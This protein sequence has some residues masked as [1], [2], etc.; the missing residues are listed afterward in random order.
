MSD[1][2]PSLHPFP[3]GTKTARVRLPY[4][5]EH[6]RSASACQCDTENF[7]YMST[8]HDNVT[9]IIWRGKQKHVNIPRTKQTNLALFKLTNESFCFLLHTAVKTVAKQK[10]K[11]RK[12]CTYYHLH[13]RQKHNCGVRSDGRRH[14]M[15]LEKKQTVITNGIRQQWRCAHANCH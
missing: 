6:T 1:I 5:L 7:E 3:A 10:I 2:P 8:N 9:R 15:N 14:M 13:K 11:T 12:T 4:F